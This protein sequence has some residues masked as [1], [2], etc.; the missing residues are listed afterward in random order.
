MRFAFKLKGHVF[1][2]LNHFQVQVDVDLLL[3][4]IVDEFRFFGD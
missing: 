4:L 1:G 2:A 3:V